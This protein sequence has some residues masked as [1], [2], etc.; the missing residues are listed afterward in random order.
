MR[1]ALIDTNLSVE[2]EEVRSWRG[3]PYGGR[4]YFEHDPDSSPE[5]RERASPKRSIDNPEAFWLT[6][7]SLLNALDDVGFTSVQECL[8]PGLK[9]RR[10]RQTLIALKGSRQALRLPPGADRVRPWRWSDRAEDGLHANQRRLYRLGVR[11]PWIRRSVARLPTPAR[12]R[13][14]RWIVR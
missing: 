14:R 4:R 2:S 6:Q 1:A 3:R 7:A 9:R 12:K 11:H 8:N 13:L 5:E 10:D